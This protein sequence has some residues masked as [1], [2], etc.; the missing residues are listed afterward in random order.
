MANI[1]YSTVHV[2][3]QRLLQKIKADT[4]MEQTYINFHT[5][6]NRALQCQ[7][8]SPKCLCLPRKSWQVPTVVPW[9]PLIGSQHLCPP[10]FLAL[11]HQSE[12]EIRIVSK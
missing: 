2:D 8:S 11:A 4:V 6:I 7:C 1:K 10:E 9:H 12:N 5:A 3:S